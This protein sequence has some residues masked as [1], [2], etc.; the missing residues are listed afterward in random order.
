MNNDLEKRLYNVY[1]HINFRCYNENCEQYNRYG[2]R[3]IQNEFKSF[4]HFKEV[5]LDSYKEH[6]K[7]YGFYD[8][9][10]DRID[11]NGNYSPDNVKWSTRKEQAHNRSTTQYIKIKSIID[12]KEYIVDDLK[13][14]S[15]RF[16]INW[17]SV[18]KYIDTGKDIKNFIISS[19]DISKYS[20]EELQSKIAEYY[21]AKI[22]VVMYEI[23]TGEEY[24]KIYNL[25]KFCR[26]NGID[27]SAA[28][29]CANGKRK[30][31]GGFFIT[32][33]IEEV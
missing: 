5:M 27:P 10:I 15:D 7:Q 8:T 1:N 17:S 12:D 26:D 32:K 23:F 24:I 13:S 29:K 16:N 28:Y 4:E 6:V 22:P 18:K 25:K 20:P 9:T 14:L 30:S 33:I 3:G 11:N 2:G 31:A 19:C 21:N